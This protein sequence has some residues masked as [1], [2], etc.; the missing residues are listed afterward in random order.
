[1]N[2]E[3]S[4]LALLVPRSTSWAN[5]LLDIN[6]LEINIFNAM[7]VSKLLKKRKHSK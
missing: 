1:M 6:V 2:L 5:G 4:T 3:H 7:N